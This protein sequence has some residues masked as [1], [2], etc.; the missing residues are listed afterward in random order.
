MKILAKTLEALG[1]ACVMIGLIDGI[2]GSMWLELYLL[3]IGLA[4]FF[5]GWAIEKA[6][7]KNAQSG[8]AS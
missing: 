4:L 3:I 7:K 2:N 8:N 5:A 1:I 6:L